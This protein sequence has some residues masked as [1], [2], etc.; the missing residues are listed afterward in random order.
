MADLE[1]VARFAATKQ[2]DKA[3]AS[4]PA[5]QKDKVRQVLTDAL[6]DIHASL[7]HLHQLTGDWDGAYSLN[8]GGD[9][10]ILFDV[11]DEQDAGGQT[12]TVGV[13][14]IV[15]THAQLYG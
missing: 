8:V 5:R 13:L 10:R 9:L 1:A 12:L 11:V 7:L 15:G 4:L 3:F 6:T 2:F 14:I